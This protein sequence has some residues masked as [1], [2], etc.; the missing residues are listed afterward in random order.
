M[1][2]IRIERVL[3]DLLCRPDE[4]RIIN[5][6]RTSR[7]RKKAEQRCSCQQHIGMALGPFSK[8]R[9]AG[10]VNARCGWRCRH[11]DFLDRIEFIAN[12]TYIQGEVT[13]GI[14]GSN[15]CGRNA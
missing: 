1:E 7:E 14:H 10:F 5:V 3:S 13:K 8:Q 11:R 12:G 15:E 4:Q 2:T 9:S 6:E